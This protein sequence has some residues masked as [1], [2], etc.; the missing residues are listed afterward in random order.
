[1]GDCLP[2]TGSTVGLDP[3][4]GA[5]V[6][7]LLGSG[8]AVLAWRW[9]KRAAAG[10]ALLPLALGV[11]LFSGLSGTPAQAAPCPPP[12]VCTPTSAIGSIAL[13]GA[14]FEFGLDDGGLFLVPTLSG[15]EEEELSAFLDA[16]AE[17]GAISSGV[18][19]LTTD[20]GTVEFF[21]DENGYLRLA[22]PALPDDFDGSDVYVLI[23]SELRPNQA[24]VPAEWV[25]SITYSD[26]CA[27][28]IAVATVSGGLITYL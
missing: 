18:L 4:I 7:L 9:R 5:L 13:S 14:R 22:V 15:A 1:M 19:T 25:V 28:R 27:K 23:Y 8:L 3:L 16:A 11:L 24:F 26:G 10:Y 17:A 12:A 2:A 21:F 20:A 6:L